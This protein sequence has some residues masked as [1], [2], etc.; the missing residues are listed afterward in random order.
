MLVQTNDRQLH[1]GGT[2]QE[3]MWN[4]EELALAPQ[5]YRMQLQMS[6]FFNAAHQ[7]EYKPG[8]FGEMHRHSF[9]L[10]AIAA[11]DDPS[12]GNYYVPFEDFRAIL[13]QIAQHY[14]GRCLNDIPVFQKIQSTTE[15]LVQV[16]AYQM[17]QLTQHLPLEI[18]EITL[19]ES[20]TIGVTLVSNDRRIDHHKD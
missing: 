20:P 17:E 16:I 11:Y 6:V 3:S 18:L 14:E 12:D 5:S 1:T 15:N 2:P 7:I 19:N 13:R 9:Q 10:T 4:L 8:K